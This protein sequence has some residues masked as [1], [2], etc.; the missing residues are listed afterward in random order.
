MDR[1]EIKYQNTAKTSEKITCNTF[2]EALGYAKECIRSGWP[3]RVYEYGKEIFRSVTD[4]FDTH[5]KW[6]NGFVPPNGE[7]PYAG[8]RSRFTIWECWSVKP[9]K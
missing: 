4:A 9:S 7:N 8:S 6:M 1:Y 3:V 5:I 2:E